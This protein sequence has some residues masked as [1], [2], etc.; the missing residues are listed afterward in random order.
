MTGTHFVL[1]GSL[2]Q[3]GPLATRYLSVLF[4]C[5]IFFGLGFFARPQK[6]GSGVIR[7]YMQKQQR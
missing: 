7:V 6:R 2:G 3:K 1:G 5:F 4:V